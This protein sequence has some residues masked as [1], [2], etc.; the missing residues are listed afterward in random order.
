[1]CAPSNGAVDE[2]AQRLALE[3]GGVWDH[4][5]KA[6][7]PRVVRLGKPS[8]EAAD[9]VKGVSLEF[10]VE[11]RSASDRAF[12]VSPFG[13]PTMLPKDSSSHFQVVFPSHRTRSEGGAYVGLG[14]ESH[15]STYISYQHPFCLR[16]EFLTTLKNR[17]RPGMPFRTLDI[18]PYYSGWGV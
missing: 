16:R 1:M 11:E 17:T 4:G 8:E 18:R 15:K 9:R 5:G 2:L 13:V 7:A 10:M 14:R 6:F 12:F 3:S